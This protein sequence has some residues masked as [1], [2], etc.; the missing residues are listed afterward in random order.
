MVDLYEG[1]RTASTPAALRENTRRVVHA[2]GFES[3]HY[4]THGLTDGELVF[5]GVDTAAQT[6]LSDFPPAWFA[7]YQEQRYFEVDPILQH[8]LGSMI[9]AVWHLTQRPALQKARRLVREAR[10][11]GLAAGATWSVFGANGDVALLALTTSRSARA[12]R[13]NIEQ[14]LGDGCM[15]LAHIHE[16]AKKMAPQRDAISAKPVLTRRERECLRWVC[17]GKTSW[18]TARILTITERTVNF[19]MDKVNRKLGTHC[20]AQTVAKAI[21]LGLMPP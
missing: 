5:D 14:R 6:V 19:H 2:L 4:S 16:S 18:E 7:R 17:A 13:R 15:L 10:Q 9:P 21:T 1:I 8:C 20:R 11:H 12:E 3:F